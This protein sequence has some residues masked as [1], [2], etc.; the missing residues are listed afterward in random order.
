MRRPLTTWMLGGLLALAGTSWAQS[1][2]AAGEERN[3]GTR[4]DTTQATTTTTT[5]ESGHH[6]TVAKADVKTWTMEIDGREWEVH[7]AT[8]AYD[9]TTG[10]F[11]MPT[12]YTLPKGKFSFQ[13]FRDNLDRDPKDLDI[14][15]AASGWATTAL[16]LCL[17][18]AKNP[19]PN[20]L[21]R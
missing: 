16:A 2:P 7:P 4:G 19:V 14:S 17:P 12:A 18:P 20:H 15:I 10:L 9:G 5:S 1:V 21:D 8:P 13:L 6:R 11:H 3:R